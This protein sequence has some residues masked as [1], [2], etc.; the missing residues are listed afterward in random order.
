[1]SDALSAEQVAEPLSEE[2]DLVARNL[3]HAALLRASE[4]RRAGKLTR[5]E[6]AEIVSRVP[7][8]ALPAKPD[9]G[10]R[11]REDVHAL[12]NG[13]HLTNGCMDAMNAA[14]SRTFPIYDDPE[15]GTDIDGD[16][17]TVLDALRDFE[18]SY[19]VVSEPALRVALTE[20]EAGRE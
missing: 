4:G 10:E 12:L 1:M 7:R 15:A 6:V 17:V 14:L 19:I 8:A 16:A 9:V 18:P 11:L 2:T 5:T 3:V 13:F 20:Q